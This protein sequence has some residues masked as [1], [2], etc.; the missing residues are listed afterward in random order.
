M[1]V[2]VGPTRARARAI[3]RAACN[4][5]DALVSLSHAAASGVTVL[6]LSTIL[7]CCILSPV[8]G[9]GVVVGAVATV[10][11]WIGLVVKDGFGAD[12]LAPRNPLQKLSV[13]GSAVCT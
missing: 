12:S 8:H 13:L 11:V 7:D 10:S 2:V 1:V 9:D 5:G 3:I 4:K 6:A